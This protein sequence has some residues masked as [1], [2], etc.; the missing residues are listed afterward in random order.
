MEFI[1]KN[2]KNLLAASLFLVLAGVFFTLK[3]PLE[4][5]PNATQPRIYV[6]LHYASLPPEEFKAKFGDEIESR[7]L[8]TPGFDNVACVYQAGAATCKALLP[9]GSDKQKKLAETA[10]RLDPVFL[11]FPRDWKRP[12]VNFG[13]SNN[14]VLIIALSSKEYKPDYIYGK[15]A[16]KIDD[17]VKSNSAISKGELSNCFE[18]KTRIVL[19]DAGLEKRG[20]SRLDVLAAVKARTGAAQALGAV[21]LAGGEL[22]VQTGAGAADLASLLSAVV[23]HAGGAPVRLKDVASARTVP[24]E[25]NEMFKTNGEYSLVLWIS[26]DSDANLNALTK[27]VMARLDTLLLEFNGKVTAEIVLDPAGFIRT[28]VTDVSVS[29]LIGVLV[30]AFLVF[31]FVKDIKQVGVIACSVP[32]SVF[33]TVAIMYLLRLNINIISLGALSIALGLVIDSAI[34]VAENIHKK[35][36]SAASVAEVG[37]SLVASALCTVCVFLPMGFSRDMIAAVFR[38]VA[39]VMMINLALSLF[40][41]VCVVPAALLTLGGAQGRPGAAPDAA[42]GFERLT[43]AVRKFVLYKYAGAAFLVLCAAGLAGSVYLVKYRVNRNFITNQQSQIIVLQRDS[44]NVP[45]SNEGQEADFRQTED[46]ARLLAAPYIDFEMTIVQRAR[47]LMLLRLRDVKDSAALKRLLS[48]K[49]KSGPAYKYAVVDWI[50]TQ[51]EIPNPPNL[52]VTLKSGTGDAAA[53]Q[54]VEAAVSK[55]DGFEKLLWYPAPFKTKRLVIT[56]DGE[57]ISK[58]C[59]AACEGLG[60]A[61]KPLFE[62][63]YAGELADGG[64]ARPTFLGG[65]PLRDLEALK[66]KTF[67]AGGRTFRLGEVAA[68]EFKEFDGQLYSEDGAR[69]TKVAAYFKDP[70]RADYGAL[71]KKLKDEFGDRI[72]VADTYGPVR[73]NISSLLASSA[74]SLLLII[75]ITLAFFRSAGYC[76]LTLAIIPLNFVV[77]ILALYAFGSDLGINAIL[78]IIVLTGISVNTTILFIDHYRKNRTEDRLASV[79]ASLQNRLRPIAM[80]T[81]C[82][83]ACLLPVA[84]NVLPAAKPLQPLAIVICSGLAVSML[85]KVFMLPWFLYRMK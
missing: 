76:A 81:L 33:A 10:S 53:R 36:L 21:N 14:G 5:Y 37:P 29:I 1:W 22:L 57:K 70:A 42:G 20:L 67:R 28:A 84:L 3:I 49:Y 45:D 85:V 56:P 9:Y 78:G 66:K 64:R 46:E 51:F 31:F 43:G 62:D 72:T 58:L 38:D 12:V 75:L 4:L 2:R 13:D 55:L 35:G 54:A 19:D 30:S 40:F 6:Y 25:A 50:P 74:V 80:T 23:G 17:Y 79:T 11:S 18:K 47:S 77:A 34:V 83:V 27:D 60:A 7:L 39:V 8:S 59:G 26:P 15:L 71:S 69:T 24:V 52:T 68:V 32:F 44:V 61:L 73:K 82:S 65:A 16:A 41:A 48:E 63:F